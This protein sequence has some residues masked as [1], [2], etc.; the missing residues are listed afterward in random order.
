MYFIVTSSVSKK[1]IDSTEWKY[2]WHVCQ[3]SG[4]LC[5]VKK[6]RC[7]THLLVIWVEVE[8]HQCLIMKRHAQVNSVVVGVVQSD[9]V[10]HFCVTHY[11]NNA[12]KPQKKFTN[13]CHSNSKFGK[14]LENRGSLHR[15]GDKSSSTHFVMRERFCSTLVLCCSTNHSKFLSMLTSCSS[16]L[17]RNRDDR[18]VSMLKNSSWPVKSRNTPPRGAKSHS[19]SYWVDEPLLHAMSPVFP[20]SWLKQHGL[21]ATAITTR[22]DF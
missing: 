10:V 2:I 21:H 11:P 14:K 4:Q 1:R 17:L 13:Q 12:R 15:C 18:R 16:R 6:W 22:T 20:L 7:S 19:H 3:Q 8:S 9:A 5:I